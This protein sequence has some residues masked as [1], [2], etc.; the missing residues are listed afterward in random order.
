MTK[1]YYFSGTGN[2]LWSAQHIAALLDDD[3]ELHSIAAVMRET[4]QPVI[5]AEAVVI[6]FPAYAYQSPRIVRA[7]L[8]AGRIRAPYIAAFVT[9]GSL[10]GGSLAEIARLLARQGSRL[11]FGGNIPAVENYIPLFGA[12]KPAVI[13]KRLALQAEATREA[14]RRIQARSVNTLWPVHPLSVFVSTLFRSA[15]PLFIR[16][17]AVNR[18]RCT[19]CGQCAQVCPTDSITIENGLP[20]FSTSCEHCQACFNRCPARAITYLRLKA[21]TPRWRHP[22]V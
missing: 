18:E 11:S 15:L 20:R 16:L 9:Y 2:T 7:F 8:R 21:D 19:G 13:E 4:A 1:L 10:P 14:A 17:Y 3:C 5:E 12:Q 22:G 6:L